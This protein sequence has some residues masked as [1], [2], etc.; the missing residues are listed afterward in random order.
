MAAL[1]G[2]AALSERKSRVSSAAQGPRGE[3]RDRSGPSHAGPEDL[4]MTHTFTTDA[5]VAPDAGSL[6]A[7]LWPRVRA[8]YEALSEARQNDGARVVELALQFRTQA[9]LMA[10]EPARNWSEVEPKV[11]VQA[12]LRH[13]QARG[14]IEAD[15]HL[16]AMLEAAILADHAVLNGAHDPN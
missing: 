7:F 13:D 5:T 8:V 4:T 9:M 10:S 11:I 14:L 15:P 12:M 3:G 16:E 2:V 6:I 1:V